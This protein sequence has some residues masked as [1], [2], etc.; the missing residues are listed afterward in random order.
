[1]VKAQPTLKPERA[2]HLVNQHYLST[3]PLT[4]KEL[5]RLG[6]HL[7]MKHVYRLNQH[8]VITS[9]GK[10][11]DEM[12]YLPFFYD[13][14]LQGDNTGTTQEDV[15]YFHLTEDDKK[16]FPELEDENYLWFYHSEQGFIN[17][18]T[19]QEEPS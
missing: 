15:I 13:L 14:Y 3:K 12:Y 5:T 18:G 4:K 10:F 16:Q 6:Y 17:S 8:K 9:P 7:M 11:E 19:S 1:M 2:D